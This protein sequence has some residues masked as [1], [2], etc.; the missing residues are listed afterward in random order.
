MA[1]TASNA[2]IGLTVT[3]VNPTTSKIEFELPL[4]DTT[5]T[6]DSRILFPVLFDSLNTTINA[7]DPKPVSVLVNK[8]I[9]VINQGGTSLTREIYTF[10]IV[11]QAIPGSFVVDP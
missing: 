9:N 1:F 4:A 5:Y 6:A 2:F 3:S 11:R 8:T 7:L 10:T